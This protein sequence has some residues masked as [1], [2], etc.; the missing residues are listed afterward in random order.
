[1]PK[2]QVLTILTD[3]SLKTRIARLVEG[4]R[5]SILD[6]DC[7][8]YAIRILEQSQIDKIVLEY[9]SH[10]KFTLDAMQY[11][12]RNYRAVDLIAVSNEPEPREIVDALKNGALD[13]LAGAF[14]RDDLVQALFQKDP[15][16]RQSSP[17]DTSRKK[18]EHLQS[19][20]GESPDMLKVYKAITKAAKVSETVLINGESGTG[21]ELAA[22]AIHAASPV[23]A[24]PFIPVN[25]GAIPANL[26][27]SELFGYT[28]GAF[29][30]ADSTQNGF[31]QSA[32]GGTIFLDEI[33]NTSRAMQA[34]LLRVLEGNEVWRVGARTPD[35]VNVRIIAATNK[36]LPH[37][38]EQGTFRKDLF[39]RLHILVIQ[40]PPLRERKGD[41]PLMIEFFSQE[42]SRQLQKP[43]PRFTKEV[44][45]LFENYSWPGNVR[46]LRNTIKRLITMT[47]RTVITSEDL[48]EPIQQTP[49]RYP[50]DRR[51]LDEVQREH[52]LKVL[53]Q[54]DGNKSHA[55][56]ILGIT[57]KT[58]RSKIGSQLVTNE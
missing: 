17:E 20:V 4:D 6:A 9:H 41:I 10:S 52:I 44:F 16:L 26:L 56:R 57:P 5:I 45:E 39:Y 32:S 49:I 23:S 42:F 11:F 38:V 53:K 24:G 12:R 7:I 51:T 25:C 27:E 30:G 58:L 46:E 34:K 19:M 8:E 13:F 33:S 31:F 22:C 54:T 1:M 2:L 40:L 47:D 28:K 48:N 18:P 50:E 36:N 3:P 21:K 43:C 35:L 29:T 14:S 37:L 15:T 55:A